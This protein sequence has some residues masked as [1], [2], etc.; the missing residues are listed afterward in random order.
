VLGIIDAPG[1]N[2]SPGAYQDNTG[3]FTATLAVSVPEPSPML[4][5][6][7]AAI[8][9]GLVAVWRRRRRTPIIDQAQC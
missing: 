5:L 8:A 9:G 1:Y 6:G 7:V 4:L 2:G 3:T